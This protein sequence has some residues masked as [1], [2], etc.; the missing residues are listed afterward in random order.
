MCVNTFFEVERV[1]CWAF[2]K[3]F[4]VTA[5]D[6]RVKVFRYCVTIITFVDVIEI[7]VAA[8]NGGPNYWRPRRVVS[9]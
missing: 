1:P 2:Q 4:G 9:H 8:I 7:F 3:V 5:I 6:D